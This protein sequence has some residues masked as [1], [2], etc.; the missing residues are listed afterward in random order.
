M[1]L[2]LELKNNV[3]SHFFFSCVPPFLFPRA[4]LVHPEWLL[5]RMC[6]AVMTLVTHI[7]SREGKGYEK[8][9]P[10]VKLGLDLVI[11]GE[12]VATLSG[13]SS[14][15]L[16][17]SPKNAQLTQDPIY[18]LVLIKGVLAGY[19]GGCA[20]IQSA[21]L[22]IFYLYRLRF[23]DKSPCYLYLDVQRID[24]LDMN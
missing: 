12:T 23:T 18:I 2:E 7:K 8:L 16:K 5:S 21:T 9:Y 11:S 24:I 3:V 6:S 13:P 17:C 1:S 19:D 22:C 4:L 15:T 14:F 10:G 20:P